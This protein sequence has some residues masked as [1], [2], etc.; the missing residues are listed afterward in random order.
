MSESD[1]SQRESYFQALDEL[2]AASNTSQSLEE[3]AEKAVQI[4]ND[5]LKF[6]FVGIMLLNITKDSLRRFKGSGELYKRR[7][8]SISMSENPYALVIRNGRPLMANVAD[9]YFNDPM[10]PDQKSHFYL[11]LK[12]QEGTFGVVEVGSSSTFNE[13]NIYQIFAELGT[14]LDQTTSGCLKFIDRN[15]VGFWTRSEVE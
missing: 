13:E 12:A 14:L 9:M 2:R 8:L 3:F 1:I 10:Y 6:L 7:L 15:K 4:I 11:P 5:K